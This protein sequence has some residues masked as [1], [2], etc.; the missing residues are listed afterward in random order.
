MSPGSNSRSLADGFVAAGHEVR[1]VDTSFASNPRIGSPLWLSKKLSRG[2]TSGA[3]AKLREDLHQASAGFQADLHV[4]IKTVMFDQ[5]MILSVSA[6]RRVHV[7]F[8]DVSNMENITPAYLAHE[9]QWDAIVTTKM[10]NVDELQARD[11]RA[12]IAI[13][14][15][16]DPAYQRIT[17]PFR[18]RPHKVGFIGAARK[19]RIHLPRELAQ[20]LPDDGVV[21]GPRWE[22]HYP[23]GL[24]GVKILPSVV[25]SDYTDAANSIRM[26]IVLLNSENRDTHTMRSYETPAC[27]QLFLGQRTAEHS[28]MFEEGRE[29]LFFDSWEELWGQAEMALR[30]ARLMERIALA[31]HNRLIHGKNTYADRAQEILGAV[32]ES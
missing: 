19:D 11:A 22:R 26:G 23:G 6:A 16:Y 13:Q 7:S 20:R 12:V 4:A 10:H 17:V 29:A 25:L 9:S 3:N 32:N 28:A 2:V 1:I 24:D 15:A 18:N 8:D 27:G 31:G 5:E 21:F 30:D 14:G